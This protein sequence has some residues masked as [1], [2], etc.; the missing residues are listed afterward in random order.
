MI[1]WRSKYQSRIKRTS[2]KRNLET[3]YKHSQG[4][5]QR[6]FIKLEFASTARSAIAKKRKLLKAIAARIKKP[7][8]ERRPMPE[9]AV[10]T[11][12]GSRS[13]ASSNNISTRAFYPNSRK[14][15]NTAAGSGPHNS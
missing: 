9:G 12:K 15:A 11:V 5:R 4:S 14:P 10:A 3:A 6:A 13:S 2:R 8:A 7:G 1:K